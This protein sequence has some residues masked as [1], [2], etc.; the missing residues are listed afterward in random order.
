VNFYLGTDN[1]AWF[2]RTDVPLFVS[3]RRIARLKS[4]GP[5]LGRWSLDSGGF[6]ELSRAGRWGITP[7]RYAEEAAG[8]MGSIGG[9]EWAAPQDWM[10]EPFVLEMTGKS[11]AEHQ[12]LTVAS[13]MELR[14]LAPEVPWAPVLQGWGIDDYHEHVELYRSAGIDLAAEP[15]VG[16]GS[17][18]RRQ[19]TDEAAEI[20]AS[21]AIGH[22]VRLHGFGLKR[23]AMEKA[24]IYLASADSM[25]WSFSARRSTPLPGCTHNKCSN[26][27]RYALRWREDVLRAIESPTQARLF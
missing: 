5:A 8:W 11:V 24:S 25:A 26:C 19:A 21:L 10:C 4:A 22:G 20:L 23:G 12:E 1:P 14:A 2:R 9:M 15:I 27:L 16:V 17:V 7:A 6:T 3:R 13:V 18:C